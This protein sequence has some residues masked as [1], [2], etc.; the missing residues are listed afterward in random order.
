M[1]KGFKIIIL[2][3]VFVAVYTFS[4][5]LVSLPNTFANL[6]GLLLGFAAIYLTW[7]EVSRILKKKEN[8]DEE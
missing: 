2:A 3:F 8:K 5:E 1:I 7:K 6:G 4:L